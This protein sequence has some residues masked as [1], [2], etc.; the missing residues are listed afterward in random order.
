MKITTINP[1]TEE[2]L[3][4]YDAIP[5]EQVK[6][7]VQDSRMI[8]NSIWKKIDISE[9]SKLLRSLGHILHARKTE[10][11]TIITNEMGV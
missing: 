11:A 5:I 7:E 9:R 6:N 8:F 2:V 3:A 10:F 4:E 1:A